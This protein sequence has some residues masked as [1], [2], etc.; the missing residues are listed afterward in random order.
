MEQTR[1]NESELESEELDPS[2]DEL[3]DSASGFISAKNYSKGEKVKFKIVAFEKMQ[4]GEKYGTWQAIYTVEKNGKRKSYGMP[5]KIA[6]T[7]K[8]QYGV[9]DYAELI[10]KTLT[11]LVVKTSSGS[12]TFEVVDFKTE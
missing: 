12:H 11:L 5:G 7:L 10:G 6:A 4:K 9:K 1:M 2:F 3:A 8:Q